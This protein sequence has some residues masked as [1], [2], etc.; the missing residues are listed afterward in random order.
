MIEGKFDII[1]AGRLVP[2]KTP[3]EVHANLAKL[4]KTNEAQIKKLFSGSSVTI[5]KGLEYA[6]AMKYQSALKAAGAL[7]LIKE[8]GAQDKDAVK[9]VAESGNK[10][11]FESKSPGKA[12]F[13]PKEPEPAYRGKASFGPKSSAED[14]GEPDHTTHQNQNPENLAETE[15]SSENVSE[16]DDHWSVA[17]AGEKL[18]ETDRPA[19]LPMPDLSGLSV[20]ETKSLLSEPKSVETPEIDLSGLSVDEPGLIQEP[21]T[22]QEREVD[23]SA[24]SMAEAGE[25]IPNKKRE[26]VAVDPDT[27]HLKLDN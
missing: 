21:K 1:F 6:Q 7:V 2:N 24:L 14:S 9:P 22:K 17:I 4:F 8:H 23:T 10:A 3:E 15:S 16:G 5:K 19:P 27:S 20:D 18:P 26:E 25:K 11:S 13:G 12:T